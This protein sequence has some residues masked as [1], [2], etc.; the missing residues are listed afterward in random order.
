[1]YINAV[2]Q[3][4]HVLYSV[5]CISLKVNPIRNIDLYNQLVIDWFRSICYNV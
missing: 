4:L 1:M 3:Y 2:L 5:E